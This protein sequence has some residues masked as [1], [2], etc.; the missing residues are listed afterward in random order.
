M[1]QVFDLTLRAVDVVTSAVSGLFHSAGPGGSLLARGRTNV[2][3]FAPRQAVQQDVS[4]QRQLRHDVLR[5]WLQLL[6]RETAR[7]LPLQIPL[8][9][10]RHLQEV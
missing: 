3:F 2:V 8:V 1:Q 9:L 6:H 4:G 10:L 5:P 7:T